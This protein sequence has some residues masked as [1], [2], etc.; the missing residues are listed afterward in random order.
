MN[1]SENDN[2]TM[3]LLLDKHLSR[4]TTVEEDRQIEAWL[5][6]HPEAEKELREMEQIRSVLRR[7]VS[8]APLPEG[9]P[10]AVKSDIIGSN[11][12]LSQSSSS[13]RWY[14]AAA[15][16]L[17][18]LVGGWF[19]LQELQNGGTNDL[20]LIV[21]NVDD[22]LKS[23]DQV[24][25]VGFNDHLRCAVTHYKGDV[26][27]Y[28]LKKMREK[29]SKDGAGIK[30]DFSDL[31]P[32]VEEKIKEG[33][34]LV[35]HKCRF[36]GRYY[37]H[38]LLKDEGQMISVVITRKEEG[39][40]LVNRQGVART[41]SDIQIY[42]TA[43][44]GYE[45]AGFDADKFLVFVVSDLSEQLNLHVMSSIAEPVMGVLKTI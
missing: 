45:I 20:P 28:G 26:P 11:L 6:E 14:Y 43:M 18:I 3:R 34:L 29:L 37:V 31:V 24:L 42:Q 8:N 32:V 44:E 35:A 36:G 1:R 17:L 30:G 39:E 33:K 4:E 5:A 7:A 27:N 22:Q 10:A 13:F 2:D 16:T 15:A 38:M 12:I 41:V 23:V 19:F 21:E 40:S 9:L 25:Q